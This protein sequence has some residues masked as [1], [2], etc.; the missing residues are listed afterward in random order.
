MKRLIIC[1]DGTWNSADQAHNGTPC[2]TNVVRLAFRVA[3]REEHNPQI[4]YYGQGVGTGNSLDR[5]TGGAFGHG[6]EDNIYDAYRFLIANYEPGDELF[7][8]G[9]SRG[10]YTARSIAGMIRK[11]GILSREHV[12]RYIEAVNLYRSEDAPD[13]EIPSGFRKNY[14][15]NGEKETV[16]HFIGVWDTVGSLGVPLRGLRWIT[17]RKHQFHD[18]ELSGSVKHA[19]HALAIDERRSPFKP[20]LWQ[21]KPKEG[22]TV[23]QVWFPGVHSNVGGG[24]P[25][26][27]L[28]DIS[29][30]WMIGKA[31]TA[32]LIF[33]EKAEA[34]NPLDPNPAGKIYRSKKGFYAITK[35]Y[36]RPIGVSEKRVKKQEIKVEGED[37]TQSI[38]PSALE[39]W[40]NDPR[41][42]P[43]MLA[44]Y[45]NLPHS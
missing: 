31:K 15:V 44:D 4:V 13:K 6:L 29:L 26:R 36:D 25:D 1:C 39:R 20:T 10:A 45:L 40:D 8:F 28:S 9:F 17:K 34:A 11:C 5:L 16:I 3:K 24:Y 18:T 23:E 43:P 30:E 12:S 38:H 37:P 14:S 35:G 21:Y 7:F 32:G 33:D 22:Q 19:C 41:Y 27:R 42:R 2:P